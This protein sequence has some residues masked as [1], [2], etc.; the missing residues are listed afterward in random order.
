MYIIYIYIYI[1]AVLSE[2]PSCG[3]SSIRCK[4]CQIII[5]SLTGL[6]RTA[7]LHQF[8]KSVLLDIK[9]TQGEALIRNK[10]PTPC[11]TDFEHVFWSSYLL[12]GPLGT[13]RAALSLPQVIYSQPAAGIA[14]SS[15][16]SPVSS[17]S[18]PAG[19][20]DSLNSIIPTPAKF[21]SLITDFL[22]QCI[23]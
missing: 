4:G 7:T 1:Y 11:E 19:E 17:T 15:T 10:T 2:C 21:S 9:V 23:E 12:Y 6:N 16:S 3:K 13:D 20:S 22:M 14:L 18:S 8:Y 5:D